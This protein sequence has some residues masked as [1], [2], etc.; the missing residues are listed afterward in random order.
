VSVLVYGFRDG[1]I[2]VPSPADGQPM[3]T[4]AWS[5][6]E[7]TLRTRY[8]H[9]TT[10]AGQQ[11]I[12]ERRRLEAEPSEWF[13]GR[14]CFA[15]PEG[16][17]FQPQRQ[18]RLGRPAPCAVLLRADR[19]PD[20]CSPFEA[21]WRG[22][23]LPLREVT[24]VGY[25]QAVGLLDGS[26]RRVLRRPDGSLY[27]VVVPVGYRPLPPSPLVGVI[28]D[29]RGL[30]GELTRHQGDG[31]AAC[32]SPLHGTEHWRQVAADGTSLARITRG[33]DAGLVF[34]FAMLHDAFR[35]GDGPDPGHGR[36]AAQALDGLVR[37]DW[38]RLDSRQQSILFEAL[39]DHPHGR[40]TAE[41]TIGCC[42]DADRL[43]LGRCGIVPDPALLS[44]SAASNICSTQSPH[45][46][47]FPR[48]SA[49]SWRE[50]W[51]AR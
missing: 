34:A 41:P 30:L 4:V 26:L 11:A 18:H 46:W 13:Y 15:V 43:D 2:T 28:P 27:G 39:A 5:W 22:P 12:L 35:A 23:T 8:L 48:A 10:E 31:F 25:D 24:A 3:R 7:P 21:C 47:L 19:L 16:G 17:C 37:D 45:V 20:W 51:A 1:A 49:P 36:R 44:T 40:T 32:C 9:F 14:G 33:A 29:P 50:L 6:P 38:L 42:W